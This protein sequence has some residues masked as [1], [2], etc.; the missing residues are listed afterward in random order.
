MSKSFRRCA[1]SMQDPSTNG[2][3][4]YVVDDNADIRL[5]LGALLGAEEL[6]YSVFGSAEEFLHALERCGPGVAL[7]DLNL[8]KMDGLALVRQIRARRIDIRCVMITGDGDIDAAVAALRAGVADFVEKPFDEK[9]LL[10]ILRRELHIVDSMSSADDRQAN[11]QL[12]LS[13]LS[14]RERQ[15][16]EHL[17]GGLVNKQIAHEMGLSIRTVE[18]HRSRAM[19]RLGAKS[20]ADLLRLVFSAEGKADT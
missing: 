13:R 19:T 5:A 14:A 20:L 17:A 7:V 18:M 9:E 8:P 11:A 1:L 12:S 16:V 2:P 6:D 15:V 10:E 3:M 4:A